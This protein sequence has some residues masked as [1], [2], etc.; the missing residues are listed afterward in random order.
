MIIGHLIYIY[1][2]ILIYTR[3]EIKIEEKIIIDM[4]SKWYKKRDKNK[5]ILDKY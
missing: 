1:I 4:I 5:K 2:Y 3:R